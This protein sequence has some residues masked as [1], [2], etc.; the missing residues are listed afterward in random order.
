MVS[1]LTNS[2]VKS[3]TVG[4]IEAITA[5]FERVVA[6]VVEGVAVTVVLDTVQDIFE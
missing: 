2:D 6:V 3:D 5:A 1:R 4:D